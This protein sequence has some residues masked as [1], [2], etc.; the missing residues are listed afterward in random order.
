M[1]WSSHVGDAR[2]KPLCAP[3]VLLLAVALLRVR[4]AYELASEPSQGCDETCAASVEYGDL[5]SRSS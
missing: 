1:R 3:F 4:C 5:G 2:S